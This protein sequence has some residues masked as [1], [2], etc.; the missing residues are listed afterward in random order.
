MKEI[1]IKEDFQIPG[2]NIILEVGDRIQIKENS[3]SN[4]KDPEMVDKIV[5]FIK[6]N[7]FP[8][9]HEQFHKWAESQGYEDSNAEECVYAMLTVILTGGKSKGKEI[10]ISPENKKIGEQIELEHVD[11]K[12]DNPVVKRIQDVFIKKI[13][14]DHTAEMEDYY[15]NEL[16]KKELE[17]EKKI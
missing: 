17:K 5:D 16:F 13:Y 10:E 12:S 3:L 1:K 2:S 9:D 14:L 8:K 15:Q 4:L 7:P 6:S 11:Y